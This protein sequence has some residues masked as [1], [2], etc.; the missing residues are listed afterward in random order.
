[1]AATNTPGKISKRT[2][3]AAV[4]GLKELPLK[5]KD[6]FGLREAIYEMHKEIEA[7]L[8]KGY[9]FEEVAEFLSSHEIQIKPVTLK[10]YLST[11]KRQRSRKKTKPAQRIG[12]GSV[13]LQKDK[14][15]GSS[16]GK[17][18]ENKRVDKDTKS[19]SDDPWPP[20]DKKVWPP[21]PPKAWPP[22]P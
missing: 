11:F 2:I 12:D 6:S 10:Q 17:A 8:K 14:A 21:E 20:E 1:M 3:E 13:D 5:E 9:S 7:I 4:S 22:K 16:K 15:T 19:Q 18:I